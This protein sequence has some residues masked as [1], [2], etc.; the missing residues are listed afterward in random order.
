M[1]HIIYRLVC[2]HCKTEYD[3][4]YISLGHYNKCYDYKWVCKNCDKENIHHVSANDFYMQNEYC[5]ECKK[6]WV[7]KWTI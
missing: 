6:D 2:K 3:N 1:S 4:L 5:D 7:N